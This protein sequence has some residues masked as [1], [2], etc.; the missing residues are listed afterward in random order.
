MEYGWT[1]RILNVDLSENRTYQETLSDDLKNFIGGRGINSKI[2]YDRI[3]PKIDPLSSEN[4]L[5][6][7]D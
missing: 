4:V 7:G 5:I 2:A 1:G 3:R 6:F